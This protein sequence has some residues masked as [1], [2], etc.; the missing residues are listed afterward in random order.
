[1][2]SKTLKLP[3]VQKIAKKLKITPAQVIISWHVQ[4]G[5]IVLPK[6]VDPGRISENYQREFATVV[7]HHYADLDI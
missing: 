3:V 2:V 4:R 7:H 6:S 5:T 1:M